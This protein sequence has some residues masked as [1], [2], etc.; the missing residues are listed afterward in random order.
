M[1][2]KVFYI[3]LILAL[4]M[5]NIVLA[6][7]SSTHDYSE[8]T[9]LPSEYSYGTLFWSD[10]TEII[11]LE[12][13]T[14]TKK[15]ESTDVSYVY[16]ILKD[17]TMNVRITKCAVDKDGDL[18]DVICKIKDVKYFDDANTY[19]DGSSQ[20]FQIYKYKPT[21]LESNTDSKLVAFNFNTYSS[22]GHFT[23]QYVKSG[24]TNPANVTKAAASMAD[25]DIAQYK[26]TGELWTG[27]EGFTI[28]G[29]QGEV[30]Y[31]KNNWLI[32]TEGAKG[33]RAPNVAYDINK[34]NKEGDINENIPD[35]VNAVEYDNDLDLYNSA[36]ATE[37]LENATYKLFY[38]G[39]ACGIIYV[40]A[41][42][43][44]YEL[45]NPIKT[46]SKKDVREG[47]KFD[48]TIT[49]YVPNNYYA[50][51]LNF[52]DNAQGRYTSFTITDELNENLELDG[53]SSKIKIVNEGNEQI[54]YFDI[55]V[56]D[57]TIIATAKTEALNNSDFYAHSY[58]ISI[59]VIVKKTSETEI[60]KISNTATTTAKVGNNTET[61]TSTADVNYKYK[62]TFDSKGGTDCPDEQKVTPSSK[63]TD[64]DYKGEKTGY[65]FKGWTT[66]KDSDNPQIYDFDT[67][68][69]EDITLYAI[70]TPIE[71]KINYILNADDAKND[72]SNP[73][74]YTV[75]DTIDFKNATRE[76]YDFE[77]WYEDDKLTNKKDGIS[78]ET[79]D[80]TVYAKWSE[81]K[82]AKYKVEHYKETATGKYELAVTD[83]FTGKIGTEVTATAKEFKGYKENKTIVDRVNTGTIKDDES[84]VLKLYYDREEYKVTFDTVGGTPEPEDQTV[85]YDDKATEPTKPTKT[86]YTFNGWYYINDNNKEVKYDF[87]D[88]VTKNI[89]LVAKW[90]PVTNNNGN[91]ST[92]NTPTSTKT[93]DKTTANTILPKTGKTQMILLGIAICVTAII[94]IRYFKLKK[95]FK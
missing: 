66:D 37:E 80:K 87:D 11:E 78:H 72:P 41:S 49:Q 59:P 67:P 14:A 64:P 34:K 25:I 12:G 88:P 89:D 45:D 20:V 1:V 8:I 83:E 17:Q 22:E 32:D 57:K 75:E 92:S 38:S 82:E 33:V 18:C 19:K 30:Y 74:K 56:E 46:A 68:V 50:S 51:D 4:I 2:K 35:G 63:A 53:D 79:G 52:I 73:S 29:A 69:K 84:L 81:S 40:F 58:S 15:P 9:S 71:Y 77:G 10:E 93:S 27:S 91:K 31:K 39:Y 61:K 13:N 26:M 55:T 7:E 85:K 21:Y 65:E 86:G 23:M 60:S 43:F 24:T 76:G 95:L 28:D 42:P 6:E 54:E 16:K 44:T 90:T 70:W 48:Y 47:E 36:V 94:G 3:I 5:P 62:V